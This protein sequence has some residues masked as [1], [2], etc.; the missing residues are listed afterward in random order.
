M[1]AEIT[2]SQLWA[3]PSVRK[4]FFR[5]QSE[6]TLQDLNSRA[7]D[8]EDAIAAIDNYADM[9][10]SSLED[11]EEMFYCFEDNSLEALAKEFGIELID[12]E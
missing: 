8:F 1:K 9:E 12:E 7:V 2:F 11:I 4:F 3:N 10:D 5:E 6:N